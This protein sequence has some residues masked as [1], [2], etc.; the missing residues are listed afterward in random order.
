M[1]T[2]KQDDKKSSDKKNV[3]FNKEDEGK[4]KEFLVDEFKDIYYA[5][6]AIL[7]GL[8]KMEGAATTKELKN[9]INEHYTQTQG[10]IKR[11]EEVFKLM[12]EKPAKKKC[13]AIDGILKEGEGV[14]E[15]T[16]AGTM[17]RDV[18]IIISAQKVEHY[19]IATYGSL[20]ELAKTL[21][22]YDVAKILEETLHEEKS[23]D[24]SLTDLALTAVNKE[25]K[26]E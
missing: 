7:K 12:G 2:K 4:L 1:A 17:V 26:A 24:L 18:A 21:E 14:L 19:E 3:K 9:S 23:T 25:A 10:Q 5:E 20:A 16:E 22:L 15:D 6:N 11:L 8:K 13:E